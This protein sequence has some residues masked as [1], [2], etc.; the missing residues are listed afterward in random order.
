LNPYLFE[1]ANIRDQD[2]WVHQNE[3]EKAT[4]KAKDLVRM[5]VAKASL[6]EPIDRL[7]VEVIQE[8]LV[9]GG[10]VAGMSAALS[11]AEQGFQTYL[12]EEK[13]YLGGHALKV[14]RTWKDEDV[15]AYVADM[16]GKVQGHKNIDVITGAQITDVQGFVGN[17]TTTV[18]TNGTERSIQHGAAIIA[19]GAHSLSPQEYLYG[20]SDR[21]TRWHDMEKLFEEEPHRLEE[22]EAIA[23]IQCVGSREPE[24][25]YCSR[26]CC[27]SSIQQALALKEKKPDLD[28]YILYRDLRTFAEREVLYQKARRAG[29]LFIRYNLEEKPV[30]ERAT[31]DG[32]EKL[33]ITVRDHILNRPVQILVDYLN[34]ATA[35]VPK[36]QETLAKFY[37]V[38]LNEDGFFLEAH[39]KLRPVDFATD[40]VFVCGLIHYPKPIEESIAQAQAAASRASSVLAQPYVEVDPT[41]SVVNQEDCIGCGLCEASCPFSAIELIKIHGTGYKAQNISASCKGCGICSAACPQKA[42]DM[43]HFRDEQISAAIRAGG[44]G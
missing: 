44:Q 1:F 13:D 30:V 40:G 23:F 2:S 36:N 29:V 8:A 18:K 17:F 38:P 16:A 20:E 24:R 3:P 37:K 31:V 28:V 21:V 33:A 19:V 10:G 27:T 42:I 43:K 34:L 32:D 35:I 26:I 12:I 4:E 6:L 9:I 39:M 5:A 25:P 15:G 11:L 7:Q 22:A 41:V 14:R